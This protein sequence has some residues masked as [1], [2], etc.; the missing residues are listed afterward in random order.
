SGIGKPYGL[1]QT[2]VCELTRV[3][4]RN[5]V[6]PVSRILR[7]AIKFLKQRSP[8]I[9]LLVSYADPGQDHHGG[10]YQASNWI[11]TGTVKVP[12]VYKDRTGKVWHSRQISPSGFNKQFGEY[13]KCLKPS[14]CEIIKMPPK[15]KY[16]LPLDDEVRKKIEQQIGRASW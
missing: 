10:I 5:H 9:K 13:R 2:E 3:A 12:P 15:H 8:G 14:D 6:T 7:F 1:K 16:L 11:Y 4:M